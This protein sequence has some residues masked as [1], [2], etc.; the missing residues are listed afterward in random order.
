VAGRKRKVTRKRGKRNDASMKTK[1][2][3]PVK[4]LEIGV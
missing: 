2:G 1:R 4:E 3:G